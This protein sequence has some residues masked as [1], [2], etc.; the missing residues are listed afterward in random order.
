M[1]EA[2]GPGRLSPMSWRTLIRD[3]HCN[4]V[5]VLLGC[6]R[7]IP[8]GRSTPVRYEGRIYRPPSEANSYLLQATIGCTWNHCTYCA[9]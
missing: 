4:R 6:R 3:C 5:L 2:R 9:M 8:Y 7:P 1:P